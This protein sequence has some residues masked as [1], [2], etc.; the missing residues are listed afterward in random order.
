MSEK[1][2]ISEFAYVSGS[3]TVYKLKDGR[4]AVGYQGQTC[5]HRLRK[6]SKLLNDI[7]EWH[8]VSGYEFG[9]NTADLID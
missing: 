5:I 3:A 6:N 9:D 4:L 2:I 7:E 8:D 1:V